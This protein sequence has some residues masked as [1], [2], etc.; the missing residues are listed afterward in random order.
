[1]PFRSIFQ[2]TLQKEMARKSDADTRYSDWYKSRLMDYRRETSSVVKI[3]KPTNLVRARSLGYKAKQG[4]CVARVRVRR[5]GGLFIRPK[6][7]RK[8]KRMGVNK[9]T[10]RKSIQSIAEERAGKKFPNMEVLNSYV[11][12]LDGKNKYFEV[13]LVDPAS[14]SV[15][16]DKDLN[17]LAEP[18]HKNRVTRGKTSSARKTRGLRKPRK[19]GTE[20]SRPSLRAN[21]RTSK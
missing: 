15:L 13:I 19:R 10:R 5:G 2:K 3:E 7:G 12:G 16:K 11:I 14:P 4:V 21:K 8:P 18:Q 20:K 6:R 9:L 17:W 1:M